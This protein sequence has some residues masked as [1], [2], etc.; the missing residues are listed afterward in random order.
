MSR[1]YNSLSLN[2]DFPL[3]IRHFASVLKQF[4][5]VFSCGNRLQFD[6]TCTMQIFGGCIFALHLRTIVKWIPYIS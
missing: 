4:R 3:R 5:Q 2:V 1:S 6:L